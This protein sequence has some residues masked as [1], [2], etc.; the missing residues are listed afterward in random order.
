MGNGNGDLGG[1]SL[2]GRVARL[3]EANAQL[4]ELLLDFMADV[5]RIRTA[6]L[7][8]RARAASYAATSKSR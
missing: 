7:E 1:E 5:L 8:P 4:L 3:E 2:E 6:L